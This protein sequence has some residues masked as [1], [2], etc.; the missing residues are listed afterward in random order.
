[1]ESKDSFPV[2]IRPLV[3]SGLLLLVVFVALCITA[4]FQ[5]GELTYLTGLALLAA[6]F[7]FSAYTQRDDKLRML[8]IL[9][10][11]ALLCLVLFI[12]AGEEVDEGHSGTDNLAP[13]YVEPE[14][15]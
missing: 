12:Y 14:G 9:F 4:Y 6:V 8:G 13:R 11:G 15:L 3:R 2:D 10:F 5:Q 7:G 1:M